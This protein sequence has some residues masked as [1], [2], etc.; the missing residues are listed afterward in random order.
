VRRQ[1][2]LKDYGHSACAVQANWIV[3]VWSLAL[4]GNASAHKSRGE[5]RYPSGGVFDKET[6]RKALAFAADGGYGK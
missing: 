6:R 3:S 4:I 2:L 5:D 1:R